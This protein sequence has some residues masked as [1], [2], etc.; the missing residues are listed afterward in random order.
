MNACELD[1]KTLP[2]FNR[3]FYYGMP[4]A[5][6]CLQDCYNTRMKL[7]FGSLAEK[8]GI[9]MDVQAMKKEYQ[10]YERWSP[11]MRNLKDASQQPELDH[12]QSLTQQLLEKT[13]KE[14]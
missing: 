3:N 2:N 10:R 7:H 13:R 6:A 1:D 12:M 4:Q 5:Q 9:L 8:E 11:F 14:R